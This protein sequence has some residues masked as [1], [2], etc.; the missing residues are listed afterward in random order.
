MWGPEATEEGPSSQAQPQALGQ[1]LAF[2]LLLCLP[3][4]FLLLGLVQPPGLQ[5]HL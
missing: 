4:C 3:M 5:A 2:R 1:L